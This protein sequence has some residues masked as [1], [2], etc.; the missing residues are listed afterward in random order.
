MARQGP[1]RELPPGRVLCNFAEHGK[2]YEETAWSPEV[3][4][5]P[6]LQSLDDITH[7]V[8]TIG[9]CKAAGASNGT[10][11]ALGIV[12]MICS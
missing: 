2:S 11:G 7:V 4:I 3:G 10:M 8:P 12:G 6:L 5:R 1:T 9:N